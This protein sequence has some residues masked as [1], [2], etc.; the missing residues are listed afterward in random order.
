MTTKH[1]ALKAEKRDRAGKGAA[2]SLRRENKVPAVIY[3][4]GKAP[5]SITLAG[6]DANLEYQKG[7]MFTSLC[8]MDVA[9]E[10]TMV[11]ARDVQLHPVSD[12][13]EHIDFL[14][15]NNKTLIAV[16][17]PVELLNYETSKAAADKGIVNYVRYEVELVCRATDIPEVIEIEAGHLSIGDALKSSNAKL[18]AGAKFA[19]SDRDFT[20]ATVVAPRTAEQELAAELAANEA[21]A[22]AAAEKAAADAAAKEAD[23]KGGDGKG[24]EKK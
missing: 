17:V 6:K 9:G 2:R 20:I 18:P 14:R 1:Y 8:D 4:D 19:I 11:L 22:A 5:V 16:K 21:L 10:K 3:G 13:V 15:V 12:R 23:S 24:G 7:H